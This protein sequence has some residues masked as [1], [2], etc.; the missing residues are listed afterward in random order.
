LEWPI[1][2]AWNPNSEKLPLIGCF[3]KVVQAVVGDQEV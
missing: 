1:G 3:V 2:I